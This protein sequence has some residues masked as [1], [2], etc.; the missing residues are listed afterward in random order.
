VAVG[1]S[2]DFASA[3]PANCG[4]MEAT[5]K[6]V[7]KAPKAEECISDVDAAYYETILGVAEAGA[8]CLDIDWVLGPLLR[9]LRRRPEA[10]GLRRGRAGR[11]SGRRTDR[12]H[13]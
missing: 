13:V 5:H 7:G 9:P 2:G 3:T 10:R 8:L 6:V 1:G 11:S 12:R 4:S